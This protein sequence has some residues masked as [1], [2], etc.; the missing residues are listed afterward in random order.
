MSL[1]GALR[2][3]RMVAEDVDALIVIERQTDFAPHWSTADYLALFESEKE[4]SFKRN[5]I[6]AELDF[7][8]V[9]FAI[10]RLVQDEAELESIVVAADWRGMGLGRLLLAE[11]AHEAKALGASRLELEVRESNA[12]AIRLYWGAGFQE[13]SRRRGYYGDPEEDAVLMSVVL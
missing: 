7:D 12:A 1:P 8:I 5:A 6:I 9:G 2:L 4:S 13:V 10:F 11:L 3:R